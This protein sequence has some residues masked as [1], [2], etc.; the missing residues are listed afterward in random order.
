MAGVNYE[1]NIKLNAS[2]LNTQFNKLE[3]RIQKVK[4]AAIKPTKGGVRALRMATENVDALVKAQRKRYKLDQQIRRLD[5]AGVKTDKLRAELGK[6]TDAQAKRQFGTFKQITSQLEFNIQKEKDKLGV[7]QRQTTEV[8]R[9]IRELERLAR[10]GGPRSPIGGA[11]NIPGS[12]A[13]IAAQAKAGSQMFQGLALG[14]G[15]P[16]LFGGGPGAVLGGAAGGLVPGP[17]GFAA[18]IG[19]SAL[20]QQFDTFTAGVIELGQ[21]LN[22]LTADVD[23]II[24]KT[25]LVGTKTGAY[26]KELES[27]EMSALALEAATAEMALIVGDDGVLALKEFGGEA[28]RFQNQWSVAMSQMGAALAEFLGPAIKGITNMLQSTNAL[29]A[30]AQSSDV[31]LQK[32]S[33]DYE[34]ARRTGILF[35]GG[36]EKEKEILDQ[37]K[38]RL[39]E[40]RGIERER[41]KLKADL[42]KT[43]EKHAEAL[44]KIEKMLDKSADII[45]DMIGDTL[46]QQTTARKTLSLKQ[47]EYDLVLA[48]TAARKTELKFELERE[49]VVQAHNAAMG[50]A[51]SDREQGYL[52]EILR[53]DLAILSNKEA[54]E[55]AENEQKYND[56]ISKGADAEIKKMHEKISLQYQ[57]NEAQRQQLQLAEGISGVLGTGMMQTFDL[58]ITGAQNWGMAL[59]DIAANVLRDIARQLIQIYVI[60]Q[61]ISFMRNLLSPTP[62]LSLPGLSGEGA[63]AQPGILPGISGGLGGVPSYGGPRARGG[64]VS[65]GR[66]YLVGERGPELF[67]PGAQ[68]NIV[69]N[70]AMGGANIVVNVD[71]KGTQAQGNQPNS[72]ALGRAIGAAVQAEL[73]KQKRPGGLLA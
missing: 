68:G 16:L 64:A 72:A 31:Q 28:L 42:A 47:I 33:R 17:G 40:I 25:G 26:I 10:I 54:Q 3:E 63:L 34:E 5:E 36:P 50:K 58:L 62:A 7:Q 2:E 14:A 71:A 56:L 45:R 8:K 49:K 44:E 43:T 4:D 60:E 19:L 6:A 1:V 70:N 18:Q 55:Q 38:V 21:A 52:F 23:K 53:Y 48:T 11:A 24:E 22:P 29:R 30:A 27:A 20:G 39:E 51:L 59:R 67:M 66:P 12:P 15:F 35:G 73:I 37:I 41:V 65:A 61:A 9:Q 46:E 13:A 57:L 32:L 69:P